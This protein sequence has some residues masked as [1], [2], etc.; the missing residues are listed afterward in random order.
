MSRFGDS[1]E[2]DIPYALWRGN[3]ERALKGKR[4]QQALREMREALLALPEKKL[5]NGALADVTYDDD[6]KPIPVGFCAVGAFAFFKRVKAGE[7][8]EDV[9]E[10]LKQIPDDYDNEEGTIDEGRRQ[11][12]VNCLAYEFAQ[13]NDDGLDQWRDTITDEERYARY[14]AWVE[15]QIAPSTSENAVG[16]L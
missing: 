6:D 7:P 9:L 5:I 4:G 11:G 12:L 2:S 1:D 15:S 8:V 13:V 10:S 14:L 16:S 3:V